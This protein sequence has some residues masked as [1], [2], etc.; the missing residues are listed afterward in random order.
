MFLGPREPTRPGFGS[1]VRMG[2]QRSQTGGAELL[3]TSV[4]QFLHLRERDSHCFECPRRS[5]GRA[6]RP[7]TWTISRSPVQSTI[8]RLDVAPAPRA[9]DR[10]RWPRLGRKPGPDIGS[11]LVRSQGKSVSTHY[12]QFPSGPEVDARRR[13]RGHP[14][15]F[16]RYV[17][18][19]LMER[20][21]TVIAECA[22]LCRTRMRVGACAYD[23]SQYS[24]TSIDYVRSMRATHVGRTVGVDPESLS[25]GAPSR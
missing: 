15:A 16:A 23:L 3:R 19:S 5:T 1:A 4:G 13:S 8:C 25:G 6:I 24:G 18:R 21:A 17:K 22:R 12:L 14:A 9:R 10:I 20:I 7:P 2:G 11:N